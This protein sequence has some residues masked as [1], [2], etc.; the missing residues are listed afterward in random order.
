[1][2]SVVVKRKYAFLK[3]AGK[4]DG[5]QTLHSLPEAIWEKKK[6]QWR[7][8]LGSLAYLL[9]L[10]LERTTSVSWELS[11]ETEEELK[12]R[13]RTART[14][15]LDAVQRDPFAV[16]EQHGEYLPHHCWFFWSEDDEM[17]LVRPSTISSLRSLLRKHRG[18]IWV[19]EHRSYTVS[20]ADLPPLL[21]TL[22]EEQ[23]AFGVAQSAAERLREGVT[24]RQQRAP[25]RTPDLITSALRP[26]LVASTEGELSSC[27]LLGSW[28]ALREELVVHEETD[29]ERQR[30]LAELSVDGAFAILYHLLRKGVPCTLSSELLDR[31]ATAPLHVVPLRWNQLLFVAQSPEPLKRLCAEEALESFESFPGEPLFF[32]RGGEELGEADIALSGEAVCF[33][34]GAEA[35]LEQIMERARCRRERERVQSG[36]E[37]LSNRAVLKHAPALEQALYPHQKIA[38]RWFSEMEGGLL[39][40]DMGLGKTVSVLAMLSELRWR[41]DAEV[42]LVVCPNSLVQNWMQEAERWLPELR[43]TTPPKGASF[44]RSYFRKLLG[45]EFS[46]IV[47]VNYESF[48][49]PQVL[50]PLQEWVQQRECFLCIDESQRVKNSQSKSFLALQEIA[51]LCPR[52]ILLSGTP[53]PKDVSDLWSQTYLID[54]GERYGTHYYRW[55]E[56]IAELGTKFSKM[57]VSR[58]HDEEVYR[59]KLR[60]RE[61]LLRRR[62]EDVIDLPEKVFTTRFVELTGEQKRRF[63]EVCDELRIQMTSLSG[64]AFYRQIDNMLEEFLRAV[65][66]ASNPRLVDERFQGEP[67]KFLEVDRLLEEIIDG[68]NGKVVLWTN[69]VKNVRELTRRYER[70]G[71]LPYSGE[72][73]TEERDRAVRAF[74]DRESDVRLLVAIPAAGGVGITLTAAQTAIY[75]EKT[76]NAEHWLQSVDRIHRIGQRG[77]VHVISLE[78]GSVDALISRN[79]QKKEQFL[80]ELLDQPLHDPASEEALHPSREDLLNALALKKAGGRRN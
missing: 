25:L 79:L 41:G 40:D 32:F 47:V 21:R 53:A 11:G 9:E 50:E 34:G 35:L 51:P 55:L 68:Q 42:L 22:R 28:T 3:G 54:L 77:M 37:D 39:G 80:R 45:Y 20:V 33:L 12:D 67:A 7:L 74:Q 61:L 70:Y 24:L 8:P 4:L 78:S 36:E 15:A 57:A 19:G 10:G 69:Y 27:R 52:R 48:R 13:L 46:E 6:R 65:Q 44:R 23:V 17:L 5:N 71:A 62:K 26:A 16:A 76:W 56:S 73:N 31:L 29:S 63:D 66:V 38:V 2:I 60:F 59:V 43:C 72:Q 30:V 49:S 18:G 64:K 14:E 75:L 1:M 58:F